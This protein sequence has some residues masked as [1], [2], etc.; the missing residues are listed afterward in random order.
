MGLSAPSARTLVMA[1]V[2]RRPRR[3]PYRGRS[4]C[5]ARST[6]SNR[7]ARPMRSV[8][9]IRLIHWVRSIA[10]F[11]RITR[12]VRHARTRR[13]VFRRRSAVGV[14]PGRIPA[15]WLAA[16][17]PVEEGVFRLLHGEAVAAARHGGRMLVHRRAGKFVV[18]FDVEL[19]AVGNRPALSRRGGFFS[20]ACS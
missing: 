6:R 16:V 11:T 15:G 4:A 8:R 5:S 3:P 12:R 20:A 2:S 17:H 13:R 10:R 7:S 14:A 18:P 1:A 19:R 9:S